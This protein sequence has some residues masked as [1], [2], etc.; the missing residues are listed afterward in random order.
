MA[1]TE[2]PYSYYF[3]ATRIGNKTNRITVELTDAERD[4]IA[5]AYDLVRLP[6]FKA[7]LEIRPWR[8][9]GL[10]V[11]GRITALAVQPCVVTLQPVECAVDEEFDRT[12]LP[13]EDPRGRKRVL[14]DTLEVDLDVDETDPPDY[15]SGSKVDLGAVMCEHF[16]LGLDPFPRADGVELDAQYA[17]PDEEELEEEKKQKPS[18]FAALQALKNKDES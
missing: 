9:D 11:R 14:D 5:Q 1:D 13:E 18:P 3:D 12:F 15:F 6:E 16:A 4:A 7:E 10:A 17:P 8:R 2:Y